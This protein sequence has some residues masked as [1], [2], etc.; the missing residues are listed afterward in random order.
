MGYEHSVENHGIAWKS[1]NTRLDGNKL[2][3]IIKD[4]TISEISN[5]EVY[6][7]EFKNGGTAQAIADCG[8]DGI[9]IINP[10]E[11]SHD[12]NI[13]HNKFTNWG[14]W[15]FAIDL[16]GNGERIE[17]V[18]F[19]NNTC[20]QD[21]TNKAI[22]G[23]YRGLGWIDFEAKKCFKNLEVNY[24]YVYGANGWAF[25]GNDKVSE[26]ISIIGNTI[27]TPN[28]DWRSRYPYMFNFYYVQA[29]NVVF[30]E[31]DISLATGSNR[32]G[33]TI[34]N[35]KMEN[36]KFSN[37]ILSLY[38]PFGDIIIEN[39]IKEDKS[40]LVGIALLGDLPNTLDE[41]DKNNPW[42]N[43][44]FKNN[45]GGFSGNVFDVDDPNRYNYINFDISGNKCNKFN[46]VAW[47]SLGKFTFDPSQIDVGTIAFSCRGAIFTSKSTYNYAKRINGGGI[48]KVGDVIAEDDK[49]KT[50]CVSEGYVPM[51]GTPGFAEND[52]PL[53]DGR[54]PNVG[55]AVYTDTDV[56]LAY[57][58]GIVTGAIEEIDG[59]LYSGDVRLRYIT[60]LAQTEI[61]KK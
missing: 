46:L 35:L 44:I 27:I 2:T 34:Y 16:G 59:E 9:L 25:N 28:Y 61:I 51:Q 49:Q 32:L 60:K 5:F 47:D 13:H 52:M 7:C 14:R 8:G 1:G 3:P 22:G 42:C 20:I 17:N 36:N 15:A 53:V 10:M 54:K 23:K 58:N 39:N 30:K 31:N 48:Y 50:I 12:I 40:I 19:N 29:K 24:N 37:S 38:K 11:N 41:N 45:E 33:N 55:T 26:N 6:D 18:K 57:N 4:G 21:E 56:Y 43:I